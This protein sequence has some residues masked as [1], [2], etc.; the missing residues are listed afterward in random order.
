[1]AAGRTEADALNRRDNERL[2][3]GFGDIPRAEVRWFAWRWR[4]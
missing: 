2:G 3:G 1:M 4:S